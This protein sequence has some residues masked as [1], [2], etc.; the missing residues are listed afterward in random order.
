MS[1]PRGSQS[2]RTVPCARSR[3]F[4]YRREEAKNEKGKVEKCRDIGRVETSEKLAAVIRSPL[5]SAQCLHAT[6]LVALIIRSHRDM[7]QYDALP[8]LLDDTAD[9]ATLKKW[10]SSMVP[11]GE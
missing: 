4:M 6:R 7:L 1:L 5:F 2:P 9:A 8:G 3:F 10:G 11:Q